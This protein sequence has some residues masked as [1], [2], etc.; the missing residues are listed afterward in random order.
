MR[1]FLLYLI[2][3]L[4]ISVSIGAYL[5]DSR[6]AE[7]YC[8]YIHDSNSGFSKGFYVGEYAGVTTQKWEWYCTKKIQECQF[9]VCKEV[10]VEIGENVPTDYMDW[11]SGSTVRKIWR[12]VQN[13]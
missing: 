2:L 4:V 13:D 5:V 11:V 12:S 10:G 7:K 8:G 6:A 1:S 3:A 9:G